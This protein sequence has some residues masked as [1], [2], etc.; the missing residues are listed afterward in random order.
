MDFCP[1]VPPAPVHCCGEAEA[2][3]SNGYLDHV[4]P[5]RIVK[6]Y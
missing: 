4:V 6:F 2:A 1:F 5:E 3:G